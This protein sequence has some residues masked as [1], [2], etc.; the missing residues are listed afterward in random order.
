MAWI[1][2]KNTKERTYTNERGI[3]K[4]QIEYLLNSIGEPLVKNKLQK[5][6]DEYKE[7]KEKSILKD[8]SDEE[9]IKLAIEKS[10]ILEE[11]F[12]KYFGGKDD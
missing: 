3:N 7:L 1:Y 2:D 10:G 5:M 11:K 8:L 6:Y 12:K 9:K 4:E